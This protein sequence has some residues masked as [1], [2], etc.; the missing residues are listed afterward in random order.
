M[1]LLT[2]VQGVMF[3]LV[4]ERQGAVDVQTIITLQLQQGIAQEFLLTH[5]GRQRE[6]EKER[7]E[8]GRLD[9]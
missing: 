5:R 7:D 9:R 4:C 6:R 3:Y 1:C 2:V 8:G